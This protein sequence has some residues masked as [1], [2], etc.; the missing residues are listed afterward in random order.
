MERCELHLMSSFKSTIWLG[1]LLNRRADM[2][3]VIKSKGRK[4]EEKGK[5]KKKIKRHGKV[6]S[7]LVETSEPAGGN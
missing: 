4:K 1:G 7:S 6:A 5:K 3:L 2:V